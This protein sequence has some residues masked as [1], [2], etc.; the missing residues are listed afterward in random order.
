M[1]GSIS[2]IALVVIPLLLAGAFV[3]ASRQDARAQKPVITVYKTPSCGCCGKWIEHMEAEGYEVDV[4]NV[5]DPNPVKA[6]YGV[7]SDLRSCHTAVV[8]GYVVEGHVPGDLVTRMLAE[9]PEV[10]GIAVPGMPIGS[11]GME[12]PNPQPYDVIA[13]DAAGNRSVFARR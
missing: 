2:K 10:K 6:E 5:A 12:G 13:F 9:R 1:N 11:P 7:P 4:R 3:L 8:D